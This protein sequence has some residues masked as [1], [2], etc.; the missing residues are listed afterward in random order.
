MTKYTFI[1]I[2]IMMMASL[3][4]YASTP[5]FPFIYAEGRASTNI[6]PDKAII[7]FQVF[8]FDAHASNAVAVVHERSAHVIKF[9]L[10]NGLEKGDII[11]YE[12]SK[13]EVRKK[14]EWRALEIVGYNV[15]RSF[16][17]T[18]NDIS[19]YV[20]IG[21]ALFK[22]DNVVDI[23]S[24][25][26]RHDHSDIEDELLAI[27]CADAK[28]N[29]KSMAAGFG[30]ELGDV[31][32]ISKDGFADTYARFGLGGSGGVTM[33]GMSETT[34]GFTPLLMPSTISFHS[35]IYVIKL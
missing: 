32:S 4:S 29:A 13:D 28:R 11:S 22:M 10:D 23:E 3:F 7:E 19:K 18:I 30:K 15:S 34:G 20:R 9:L 16:K 25:F 5:D 35:N 17:V 14:D 24:S 12:L 6:E 2:C 27:A 21:G 1:T 33:Y 26:H 8:E 31:F